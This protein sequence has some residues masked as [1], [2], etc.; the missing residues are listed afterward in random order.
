MAAPLSKNW[1]KFPPLATQI[2]WSNPLT[3]NLGRVITPSSGVIEGV[4]RRI[5]TV[6]GTVRRNPSGFTAASYI[7]N[8]IQVLDF[9]AST[10]TIL[11]VAHFYSNTGTSVL[12]SRSNEAPTYEQNYYLLS[13][14]STEV[15]KLILGHKQVSD[16]AYKSIVSSIT[17][18]TGKPSVGVGRYDGTNLNLFVNGAPAGTIAASAPVTSFSG[19]VTQALAVDGIVSAGGYQGPG[20][21]LI[22]AWNR[23]LT[24][25][26]V[27]EVSENPWQL[28]R[29]QSQQLAFFSS[30]LVPITG[31]LNVTEAD[32]TLASTGALAISGSLAVTEA[33]DSL[34]AT[35]ALALAGSLAVTEADDTLAST[36]TLPLAGSLSV[37]E[38]G[39][40]LA[41]TS[42]LAI[43]GS[44]SVTEEGDTLSSTGSA[45]GTGSLNVTE[46]SDTLSSTGALAIA[47]SL[48]VTEASDTL[49]ATGTLS[50]SGSLSVTEEDDALASTGALAITG[51]LSV[52]EDSDT[53]ASA[54]TSGGVG[55]LNVTEEGDTLTATATVTQLVGGGG[56]GKQ[57]RQRGWANE[58]ARLEASLKTETA[59]QEVKTATKIL[60]ASDSE[61]AR[62]VADL[63]R[64]YESAR[65]TL[66]QLRAEVERLR[67]ETDR[68][69]RLRDEVETAAKVVEIFAQE[70]AELLEILDI[71]DE[72]ESRALLAAL[73]IA[74]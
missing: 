56:M 51:S 41:S 49:A 2:D 31:T 28:F 22:A 33:S 35:G 55:S 10:Y 64:E 17:P 26:E 45:A 39:D 60:R 32:D 65:A 54:G 3:R 12:F 36:G 47:G 15:G 9:P 74:A 40:T 53:L 59:A 23:A 16:N 66:E 68:S 27:A 61:S 69:E 70:E 43:S 71:I 50:I 62:R 5:S 4:T 11:A 38:E 48:A 20:V 63:V 52:T 6:K 24:D 73:G 14:N 67:V 13:G 19:V 21:L 8:S 46:E 7:G 58:R 57:K 1:R 18:P 72:M 37:T 29:P 34:A 42:A 44:L 30:P 25:A